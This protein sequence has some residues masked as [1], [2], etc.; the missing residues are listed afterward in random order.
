MN[1]KGN[2]TKFA[3]GHFIFSSI[4]NI[5]TSPVGVFIFMAEP[6]LWI[7]KTFY[8]PTILFSIASIF[9]GIFAKINAFK[10][11]IFCIGFMWVLYQLFF[12]SYFWD[13]TQTADIKGK[14]L[15]K[16]YSRTFDTAEDSIIYS[17]GRLLLHLIF[18]VMFVGLCYMDYSH[19]ALLNIVDT[20]IKYVWSMDFLKW[21]LIIVEAYVLF[22]PFKWIHEYKEAKE[23][24]SKD[25]FNHYR[26]SNTANNFTA[27]PS[28]PNRFAG[29]QKV[30][31][32]KE[33]YRLMKMYHPDNNGKDASAEIAIQINRE[34]EAYCNM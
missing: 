24:N 11:I 20:I 10:W 18:I 26:N 22:S 12:S 2:N 16:R 15:G 5:L 19:M 9:I 14:M 32:K 31:A 3:L 29:M 28:K 6:F 13:Y 30:A 7:A 8:I 33:Y 27:S 25:R 21:L 4:M 23:W 34:Y 1:E 17:K